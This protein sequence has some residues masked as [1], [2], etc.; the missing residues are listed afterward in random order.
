MHKLFSIINA[1]IKFHRYIFGRYVTIYN[2]HKPL[3]DIYK[4]LLLSTAMR[5]QRMCLCLQRYDIR[6]SYRRGKDMELVDNTP[7]ADGLE[8][9]STL[10]LLSVSDQK[11]AQPA[12]H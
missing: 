12:D 7:E 3:E 1:G 8:C 10:N 11:Y 4:K 5:I 2:D 9:V 6:V